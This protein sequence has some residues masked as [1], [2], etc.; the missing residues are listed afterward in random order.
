MNILI[1]LFLLIIP[2]AIVVGIIVTLIL[3]SN[4]KNRQN[5]EQTVEKTK[6][7][8]TNL[9]NNISNI[10][11]ETQK[12]FNDKHGDTIKDI[13]NKSVEVTKD[14]IEITS[15]AIKNGFKKETKFCRDCGQKIDK[16][17]K[18]CEFCGKEQ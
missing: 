9:G 12:K 14:G 13:A 18:F 11:A 7:E 8:F 5:V 17:A 4:P 1:G 15:N 3:I 6:K 16:K 10:A 2:I